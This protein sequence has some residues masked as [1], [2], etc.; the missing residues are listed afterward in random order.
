MP[1]PAAKVKINAF[2]NTKAAF[3]SVNANLATTS[4]NAIAVSGSLT[5]IGAG[6]ALI[7]LS[8]L[9]RN[10]IAYGSALTDASKATTTSVESLQVLYALADKAGASHSVLDKS[11][12]SVQKSAMDAA[13]GLT[14]YSREFDALNIDIQEFINLPA[15]RKLETLAKAMAK[16]EN[17]NVAYTAAVGILG[18]RNAPALM[19]VLQDLAVDGFD[20]TARAAHEAG[21][22]MTTEA[23]QSM[24]A[25]ADSMERIKRKMMNSWSMFVVEIA[26]SVPALRDV[27]TEIVSVEAQIERVKKALDD[28]TIAGKWHNLLG[29]DKNG[30]LSWDLKR[31]EAELEALKKERAAL[32]DD[33]S[34]TDGG[35][36][37]DGQAG[38]VTAFGAAY[39]N[40]LNRAATAQE[41]LSRAQ[42]NTAQETE[43]LQSKLES[44]NEELSELAEERGEETEEYQNK[45]SDIYKAQLELHN[46][47]KKN[48]KED[49]SAIAQWKE[50]NLSAQLMVVNAMKNASDSMTDEF[51]EFIETGTFEFDQ[52]VKSWAASLAQLTFQQGVANPFMQWASAGLGS[53]F[54]NQNAAGGNNFVGPLPQYHTGGVVGLKADEVPAVLK[55]GEEVLTEGDSRHRNNLSGSSS[56]AGPVEVHFSVQAIDARGV[57]QLLM[58]R[59]PMFISMINDAL[60][61]RG[62]GGI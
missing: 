47:Q 5:G 21:Q 45:L 14:T 26:N 39:E 2:D 59:R 33:F 30:G 31:L 22:I 58:E 15:E 36:G 4:K 49:V 46:L 53:L 19:E 32:L 42:M 24:D 62:K 41:R 13:N 20:A 51:M 40:A 8:M 38:A 52:M 11:L 54:S 27:N 48:R 25:M 17:K 44:L 61:R 6:G 18:K 12:I 29:T 16:A 57:D 23:A 34:S 35:S 60:A 1:S 3:A 9:T 28:D 55:K 10:A 50:Q 43:Y 7:G 56:A 37:M